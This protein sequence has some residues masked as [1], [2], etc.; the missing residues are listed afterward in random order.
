MKLK[1]KQLLN[2]VTPTFLSLGYTFFK[3][4]RGYFD[5]FIK[6]SGD[7]Y[8][9]VCMNRDRFNDDRFT[10]DMYLS[11]TTRFA[12]C[13]GDIPK[14]CYTR[15]GH[16]LTDEELSKYAEDGIIIKDV[17][18]NSTPES[19]SDFFYVFKV[20][21]QRMLSDTKLIESIKESLDM[22]KLCH[23]SKE[24][25]KNIKRDVSVEEEKLAVS[26]IGFD[27]IPNIWYEEA[28]KV[29]LNI[30]EAVN[31]WNINR[32]AEDAYRQY[33]LTKQDG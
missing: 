14:C 12:S 25:V 7:L 11:P 21:E 10:A 32:I 5:L 3:G 31:Q 20:A 6:K 16:Y 27:L 1:N 18:W 26:K 2:L 33:V 28:T 30:N 24:V 8:L 9:S 19:V 23:L 17:W 22:G 13:W 29:L 15:P 4:I